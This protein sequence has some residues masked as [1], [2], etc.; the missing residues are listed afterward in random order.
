MN[1]KRKGVNRAGKE[2]WTEADA[3][4][5]TCE[6][7]PLPQFPAHQRA[8]AEKRHEAAQTRPLPDS[9]GHRLPQCWPEGSW[10]RWQ[11]RPVW[12]QCYE[13]LGTE[14]GPASPA[15]KCPG[16]P[17]LGVAPSPLAQTPGPPGSPCSGPL[18]SASLFWKGSGA[19][20]QVGWP[21]PAPHPGV[22]GTSDP[23]VWG[24]CDTG[25]ALSERV[26]GVPAVD[27]LPPQGRAQPKGL[28]GQTPRGQGASPRI[29]SWGYIP[30]RRDSWAWGQRGGN[31]VSLRQ[32]PAGLA[33]RQSS[34][35][36]DRCGPLMCVLPSS[37]A[38]ASPSGEHNRQQVGPRSNRS[39]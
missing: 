38:L 24:P 15:S 16:C 14:V 20:P 5:T 21:Q 2:V 13:L 9:W 22:T 6:S 12:A 36:S 7:L 3:A 10:P 18:S 29:S 4:G 26:G 11:R 8:P 34:L 30:S 1:L 19:C 37:S 39:L 33:T 35:P 17:H 32:G 28:R 31:E 23:S 25:P 27:T